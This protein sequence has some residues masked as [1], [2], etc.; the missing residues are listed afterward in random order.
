MQSCLM[1]Y[2]FHVSLFLTAFI[3]S[4]NDKLS[5]SMNNGSCQGSDTR[6]PRSVSLCECVVS[7]SLFCPRVFCFVA[8]SSCFYRLRAFMLYLVL[9]GTQLVYSLAYFLCEHVACEFSH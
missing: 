9:C 2:Y 8:R 7:S 5:D 1:A 4:N 6:A 3:L